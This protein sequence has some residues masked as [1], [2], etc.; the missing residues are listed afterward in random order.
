MSASVCFC[1]G[2]VGSP[3]KSP[4]SMKTT[5]ESGYDRLKVS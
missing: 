3:V 5:G 1:P 4:A 2:T